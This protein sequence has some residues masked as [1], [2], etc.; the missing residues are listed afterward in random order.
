MKASNRTQ[1]AC[2]LA[3]TERCRSA[4]SALRGLPGRKLHQDTLQSPGGHGEINAE[5]QLAPPG[6]D[7]AGLTTH[8]A[9]PELAEQTSALVAELGAAFA[10]L[11]ARPSSSPQRSPTL[12][13]A[14][15][16]S[17]PCSCLLL[18]VGVPTPF[19]ER[20]KQDQKC[21][22]VLPVVHGSFWTTEW[23]QLSHSC[24]WEAQI[25]WAHCH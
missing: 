16:F 5:R 17:S 6:G 24:P 22:E 2:F 15:F 19:T 7:L 20:R 13:W 3:R 1:E 23:D 10:N 8:Q 25:T 18:P 21:S 12:Q 11:S 14:K 4:E 9:G